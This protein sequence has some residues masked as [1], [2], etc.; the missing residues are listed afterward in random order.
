MATTQVQTIRGP[1]DIHSLG[2][3]LPHEHLFTDLRG[4]HVPDYARSDAEAVAQVMGAYL[5]AAYAVGVMALVECST[6]GVGRN[7]EVLRRLA[8]ITP[9]H[10]IAPTGVYRDAFIPDS[11][12]QMDAGELSDRWIRDL[13][14]GMDGTD[15]R[16][17]F[18]KIALSDD[19]P[20]P[21]EVRNLEAAALASRQ[22]GAV[23]AS[24]T[25]GGAL[26]RREMDILEGAG[27]DLRR[28]IWVHAHTEPDAS[29]HLEA[30]QRGAY[31]EF[32]A[33]GAGGQ[34][35]NALAD[36]TLALIEAGF[37]EHIL[38]SHDAG[39]YQPGRAGGRPEGGFRGFTALVEEFLPALRERGVPESTLHLITVTNPARAFAFL[40]A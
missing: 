4:P 29:I 21:L 2:L 24:H 7:V 13:T 23:V 12:R 17:G 8:G 19:G 40:T 38:L 34:D 26:A 11:L 32:D 3:I 10:L 31:V 28:F 25:V 36:Y 20:S 18:I 6:V 35:Q 27:L 15:L 16:A 14:E 37:A 39:Y 1:V 22:T 30:A 33:V 9:I 5:E